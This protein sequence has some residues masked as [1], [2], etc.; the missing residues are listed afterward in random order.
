MIAL[1]IIAVLI[2]IFLIFLMF[3][4]TVA[5]ISKH[6]IYI[7]TRKLGFKSF[8]IGFRLIN[9]SNND[10]RIHYRETWILFLGKIVVIFDV[11]SKDYVVLKDDT[12]LYLKEDKE[13]MKD[14]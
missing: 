12:I 13:E 11:V 10:D 8:E 14:V 5:M 4:W 1:Y 2:L 9:L 6:N 3:R 7:T